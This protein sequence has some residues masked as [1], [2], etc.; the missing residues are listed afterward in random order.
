M[1]SIVAKASNIMTPS[2]MTHNII[3]LT[4]TTLITMILDKNVTLRLGIF[5]SLFYS[6]DAY[7]LNAFMLNVIYDNDYSSIIDI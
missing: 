4:I 3:T 5:L 1:I 6:I 2:I 7:V